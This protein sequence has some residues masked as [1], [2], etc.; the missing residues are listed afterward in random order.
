MKYSETQ[1]KIMSCL[2]TMS[3]TRSEI[4]KKTGIP[5][6]TIYDNLNKLETKGTVKRFTLYSELRGRP[7]IMWLLLQT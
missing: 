4:M 7:V 3:R 1:V 5:R 2:S 6:T